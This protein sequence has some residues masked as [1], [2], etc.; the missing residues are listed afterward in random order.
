ME[1][2]GNGPDFIQ[3]PQVFRRPMPPPG[4][5][6]NANNFPASYEN[7]AAPPDGNVEEFS[8]RTVCEVCG[9]QMVR[10]SNLIRHMKQA[11]NKTNF[12][13]IVET[14]GMPPFKIDVFEGQ[15]MWGCCDDVYDDRQAFIN[16]RRLAHGP[17]YVGNP[18]E[19]EHCGLSFKNNVSYI[20]HLRTHRPR[21][22][23]ICGESFGNTATDLSSYRVH[24]LKHRDQ[25]INNFFFVFCSGS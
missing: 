23:H 12:T 15:F 1:N 8:C 14:R 17:S 20:N 22:C 6:R 24:M 13:A 9:L 21:V 10:P 18:K 19:C 3:S 5:N 11:H 16:H 25:G 7:G 2:N 4:P